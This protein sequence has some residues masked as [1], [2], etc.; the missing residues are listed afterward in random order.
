MLTSKNQMNNCAVLIPVYKKSL[1]ELEFNNITSSLNNLKGFDKYFIAPS[2]LNLSSYEQFNELIKIKRFDKHYFE[3]INDYS[4]LMLS[5]D[6]YLTFATDYTHILIL[7]TDA[8]ILKPELSLW[9]NQKFDYIGAPWKNGFQLQIK[10]KKIPIVEGVTCHAHVGNGGLSL[11]KIKS[12]L[13]L[14]D[15][16]EDTHS[17]WVKYGH[18]ED[19]FFSFLGGISSSFILP[20]IY[21]AAQF[22]HETD[23]NYF[24]NLIGN[25]LPF[26]IHGN[27]K[28]DF[29]YLK[30]L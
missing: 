7:Q 11:R 5:K 14:F 25:S 15:E 20:N 21:K 9:L 23:S 22:S 24:F 28:Y 2:E 26:G 13:N 17:E 10:S 19:L 18:A 4:R 1:S 30:N 3:S 16:F 8:K 27:D 29:D 6:F 12:C